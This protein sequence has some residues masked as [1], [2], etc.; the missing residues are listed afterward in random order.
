MLC[1]PV[2]RILEVGLAVFALEVKVEGGIRGD[3]CNLLQVSEDFGSVA[4]LYAPLNS[5]CES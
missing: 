2:E 3:Y 5:D 4:C 1:P